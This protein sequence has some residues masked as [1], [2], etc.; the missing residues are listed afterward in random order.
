LH[1]VRILLHHHHTLPQND[2]AAGFDKHVRGC[3][4]V[5]WWRTL[6]VALLL[7][8]RGV[9][10]DRKALSEVG[11]IVLPRSSL[12]TPAAIAR[13]ASSLHVRTVTWWRRSHAS[14]I[15]VR[16]LRQQQQHQQSI[17]V[18]RRV[19]RRY[20]HPVHAV[21]QRRRGMGKGRKAIAQPNSFAVGNSLN[22]KICFSAENFRSKMQMLRAKIATLGKFSGKTKISNTHNLLRR[23]FIQM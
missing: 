14:F 5:S 12:D 9:V 8:L 11:G 13:S 2:S 6:I 17:G 16:K 3:R 20:L 19:T 22:Q 4:M 23:K 15:G 1:F 21:D 10:V 18:R 7:R